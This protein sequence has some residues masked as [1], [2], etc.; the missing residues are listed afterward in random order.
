M[1]NIHIGSIKGKIIKEKKI[2]YTGSNK[3][4]PKQK[5]GTRKLLK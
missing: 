3:Q 4:I 5:K 1:Q 2:K